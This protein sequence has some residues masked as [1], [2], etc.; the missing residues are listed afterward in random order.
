MADLKERNIAL[1]SKDSDGA[2]TIDYPL[3]S[4]EM[5]EGLE[6]FVKKYSTAL[7]LPLSIAN[8][9]TG[10]TDATTALKN[11]GISVSNEDIEKLLEVTDDLQS[12]LAIL[13]KYPLWWLRRGDGSDGPFTP[14]AA[15]TIS[16]SKQYSS[17]NIPSNVTVTVASGTRMLCS[18]TFVNN[19]KIVVQTVDKAGAGGTGGI[20]GPG[21]YNGTP[22]TAGGNSSNITVVAKGGNGGAGGSGHKYN[23]GNAAGGVS[24]GD[25]VSPQDELFM[26]ACGGSGGGGGGGGFH[27]GNQTQNGSA[28]G[29]GGAGG[30]TLLITCKSFSNTGSISANGAAGQDGLSNLHSSGGGGGGGAGGGILVIV[31]TIAAR[32][33]ITAKGGNGG[34]VVSSVYNPS[35]GEAGSN[36]VIVLKAL[37]DD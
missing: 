8:G 6:E 17:V 4:A 19:G 3:T 13:K 16:G 31:D 25:L 28:G 21:E 26:S 5:V 10:A 34:A 12:Q 2:T 35:A 9:G 36:G 18:G 14:T 32:G 20:D 24:V 33:T 22:A 37:E 29:A 1:V 11:L 30:G 7:E 23:Y 27:G 15:V